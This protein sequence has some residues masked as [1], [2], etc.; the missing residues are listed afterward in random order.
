MEVVN[1]FNAGLISENDKIAAKVK[2]DSSSGQAQIDFIESAISEWLNGSTYQMISDGER[3]YENENDILMRERKV[4]GRNGEMVK[5]DYLANN[6]LSHSFMRKLTKQKVGYLLSKP[7]TVTSANEEFQEALGNY[8]NRAFYRLIKNTARDA[9]VGGIGWAQPYFDEEGE[10]RFKR[11]PAR[12][13]IPFWKDIDHTILDAALRVY[14]VEVYSGSEKETIQYVKFYTKDKVFNYIRDDDG[15]H[16][17]EDHPFESN[18]TLER[19]GETL[20]DDEGKEYQSTEVDEMMWNRIP[21]IPIKYNPEED[22]LLKYIRHLIDDYDRRTSDLSNVIEDEPD[23]IKV[24]KDYDG[25]DKGEFVYNLSRYR[26]LFLRGSGEVSTLDTSISTEALENHL[27]RTR[28]DIFEFGGGVDTQNK[29]LGNASGVALKFVYSDLD[30]DCND[31]GAEIAWSLE[32]FAW[33]IK[34]DL[35]LKTGQDFAD[36]SIEIAFNTDI[37]INETETISNLKNS[38]GMISSK[39][40]LEQ[41]PYVTNAS[42]E[43]AQL[44]KEQQELLERTEA[45][46]RIQAELPEQVTEVNSGAAV[47]TESSE[48]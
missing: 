5:A 36:A 45:E 7:F 40:I 8:L 31:F 19:D 44:K 32:Q 11:I 29:D 37:T 16:A 38:V 27:N 26:T 25:T 35:L 17:D 18:F 15:L 39:T 1:N 3:Y 43:E 41:H 21:L 9:V 6:K 12:E 42:E 28:R 24:V 14:E 2:M 46:M 30:M 33:F 22:S 34:Q 4:I 13:V 48:E 20:V 10:L 23:R 47:T